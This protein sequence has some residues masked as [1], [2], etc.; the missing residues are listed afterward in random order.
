[1]RFVL[2]ELDIPPD[3]R[4]ECL[5]PGLGNSYTGKKGASGDMLGDFPKDLW[6]FEGGL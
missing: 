5:V 4:Q 2:G 6:Y 1:M 3:L